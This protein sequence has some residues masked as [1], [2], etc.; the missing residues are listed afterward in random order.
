MVLGTT[1]DDRG[2]IRIAQDSTEV[3]V[4]FEPNVICQE[5]LA[6]FGAENEVDKILA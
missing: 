2:T 5:R 6:V 4:H 3:H 1:R